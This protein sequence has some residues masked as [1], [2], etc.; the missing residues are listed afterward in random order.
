ML[1]IKLFL[2]LIIIIQGSIANMDNK[3]IYEYFTEAEAMIVYDDGQIQE[4]TK[5]D[6]EYALILQA[7]NEISKD[8]H[9]MPAYGIS[10]DNETRNALQ[11]NRWLELKFSKTIFHN[12]MPFDRLLIQIDSEY[13]GFNLIRHHDNI[14]EG[15]CFYLNINNNMYELD[16][17][18]TD[19]IW[20]FTYNN[21]NINKTEG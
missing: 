1:L 16:K 10:L 3:N 7:L 2:S 5:E 20:I 14:Y 21:F 17:L 4:Y 8:A 9:E 12:E 19:L 11:T 6:S 13:S 15:R 18:L